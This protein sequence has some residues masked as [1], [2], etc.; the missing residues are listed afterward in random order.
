MGHT[1][2]RARETVVARARTESGSTSETRLIASSPRPGDLMPGWLSYAVY[3]AVYAVYAISS[4]DTEGS[5][6]HGT[7]TACNVRALTKTQ[8]MG[9]FALTSAE[10]NALPRYFSPLVNTRSLGGSF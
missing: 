2:T 6:R 5:L 8:L 7:Q 9:W 3:Y 4:L 1:G 10:A